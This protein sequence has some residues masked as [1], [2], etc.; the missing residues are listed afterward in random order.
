MF[1]QIFS[2][3]VQRHPTCYDTLQS[4][5]LLYAGKVYGPLK[6]LRDSWFQEEW[7]SVNLS[8]WLVDAKAKLA[9]MAL[10]VADR[11]AKAE[12]RVKVMY[13][14]N[15]KEKK[16]EPGEL[17]LVKKPVSLVR[18]KVHGKAHIKL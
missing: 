8:D 3:G 1:P 5:D 4:F 10:I 2:V 14:R 9:E 13:D 6:L 17:V 16:F 12:A 7:P 11:E 15:A 18:W